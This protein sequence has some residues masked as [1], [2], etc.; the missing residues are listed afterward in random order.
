MKAKVHQAIACALIDL[1]IGVVTHVPGYGGS[2]TFLSYN[3]IAM[4]NYPLSFHEEPAYSIAH[5]ASICGKRSAVLMKAQGL[6]KAANAAVDSLY[7]NINAGFVSLIFDDKEG[8]HSDNIMETEPFIKGISFPFHI[9]EKENIYND[10]VYAFY[11]SEKLKLPLALIIDSSFINDD[12]EIE[13]RSD[14]K[15]NFLYK[16]EI[17]HHVVHPMFAEYQYK[18]FSAK[19]NDEDSSTIPKPKIINVPNDLPTRT[20]DAA[21]KYQPIFDY[22][23][24]LKIDFASGDTSSSSAFCLPPYNAINLVTH[25]GGSV[26]LAIGAYL[27]GFKNVWALTGDFGFISAGH[28]GLLEAVQRETPIKIVIFYNKEASATGGQ[29]I[30]KNIIMRLLAGY[31]KYIIH[32]TNPSDPFE[33]SEKLE[34]L[35]NAE[36][37]KILLADY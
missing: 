20:K 9:S 30:H 6:A 7:T 14:L 31:E 13:R 26:S 24:N 10:V 27:S 37:M 19:R 32:L 29:T 22:M 12:V 1:G 2:E 18:V 11:K 5:S 3:E 36:S 15:K 33:V 17:I 28:L 34:E 16:R 21:I 23:K 35:N 8:S 4:K 25:I